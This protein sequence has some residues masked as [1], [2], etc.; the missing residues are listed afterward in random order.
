MPVTNSN[1]AAYV[2]ALVDHRLVSGV[3]T[4]F[5]AF[6]RGFL[7]LCD[8]PSLSFLTP[9]ELEELVCGTPHY[10][11]RAL[12]ASTKYDGFCRAD[13]TV[14][15]FWEVVHSFS[16]DEKRALLAFATGCDRAPVGGLGKLGFI[17]QRSGPDSMVR[18]PPGAP[19][20]STPAPLPAPACGREPTPAAGV[21]RPR[22]RCAGAVGRAMPRLPG[23]SH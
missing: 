15:W 10:D 16:V 4:G 18:A 2:A 21:L 6:R 14:G 9:E 22:T 3:R 17:L 7:T 8:G 20:P 11:F 13:Q 23:V 12:E 1:R 19:P 5:D